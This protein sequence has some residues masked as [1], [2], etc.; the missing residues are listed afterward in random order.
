MGGSL[1]WNSERMEG[2]LRLEIRS[3]TSKEDRKGVCSLKL[4]ILWTF[5][6]SS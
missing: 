4:L 5:L 1:D 3:G 6:I 2:Y